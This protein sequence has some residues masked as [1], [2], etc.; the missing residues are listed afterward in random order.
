MTKVMKFGGTSVANASNIN[1]VIDIIML[2]FQKA[3]SVVVVSA[4]GGVT[5]DLI[6]LAKLA[7][8]GEKRYK[9]LFKKICERHDQVIKELIS[10]EDKEKV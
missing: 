1:K 4:L 2:S 8:K 10:S 5:D 7:S 3:S 9:V 6:E